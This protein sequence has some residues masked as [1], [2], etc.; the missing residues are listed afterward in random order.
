ME[1]PFSIR[2]SSGLQVLHD[3]TSGGSEPVKAEDFD[4]GSGNAKIKGRV[5]SPSGLNP[6]ISSFFPAFQ[7][8]FQPTPYHSCMLR[9]PL[10]PP[11]L[12]GSCKFRPPLKPPYLA[13]CCSWW[14]QLLHSVAMNEDQFW[15][16]RRFFLGFSSTFNGLHTYPKGCPVR[17]SSYS[18]LETQIHGDKTHLYVRE[19][20]L[21]PNVALSK[22]RYQALRLSV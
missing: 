12:A 1:E 22:I 5:W 8:R 9:P 3:L 19:G 4:Q 16:F 21:P 11:F 2:W 6:P 7:P 18:L 15:L 20:S 13:G 14:M 17:V 10:K